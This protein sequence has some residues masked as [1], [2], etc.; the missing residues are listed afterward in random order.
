M[1]VVVCFA[2]GVVSVAGEVMLRAVGEFLVV[3]VDDVALHAR[4][5]NGDPPGEKNEGD[6]GGDHRGDD[7]ADEDECAE[8]ADASD[9]SGWRREGFFHRADRLPDPPL[10]RLA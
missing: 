5:E 9:A 7:E 4:A 1:L 6:D 8:A 2:V 3:H 10:K